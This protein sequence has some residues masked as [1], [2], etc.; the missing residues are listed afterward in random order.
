MSSSSTQ[1]AA[2]PRFAR[3]RSL[4]G[5][6]ML[7]LLRRIAVGRLEFQTPAGEIVS[8]QAAAPGP[9]A[10]IVLHRWRML[11]RLL[12]GGDVAFAESF[13]DGDWSSPDLP[14]LIEFAALN[15][16]AFGRAIEASPPARL[17]NRL[18]H[19]RRANTKT[20]SRRNIEAHYDL[21]NAFYA[22]WLDRSMTY[23]AALFESHGMSL[24]DAQAA[25]LARVAELLD[26]RGGERVLEIGCGWGALAEHL[27]RIAGCHVTGLTL[28]PAQLDFARTRLQQN[29]LAAQADL[30]LQDYRDIGG[31]FDRIA[32]IEM[33]EAVGQDY[34]AEYFSRLR[35][36][37]AAGGTA[38]LQVIT[39]ADA[40][41][42]SYCASPDFIQRYIFPGGMLP[43]PS[44]L[45]RCIAAAGLHLRHSETFG[46]SYAATLAEWRRRF[47][48]AWPELTKL[49]FDERFRRKWDYYLAYCEGGFRAG[50][51][52]VG[53]Y[54]LA[55]P[56]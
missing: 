35:A 10:R 12:F 34:W 22:T 43:S 16:A 4:S 15:Q 53:L 45:R 46:A 39:I 24:E 14:S 55:H 11:R 38:V 3:R 47:H 27:I 7:T 25:K 32:S 37:L 50:A 36:R 49:G 42:E 56:A 33:F 51:I 26:L 17:L 9:E 6:L 30:R 1:F 5:R 21:G 48:R 40:K 20:G 29:E 13:M 41:F 8:H 44:A 2:Q 28:S 18:L 52:D 19:L 23:S 54:T 31:T